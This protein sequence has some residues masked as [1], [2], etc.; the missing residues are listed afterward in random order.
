[1]PP[2]YR[3]PANPNSLPLDQAH[4]LLTNFSSFLTVAIHNLLFYRSIYPPTTFLST[5]AYNLPV[6]QNRHPKVCAWI[7]DAV[8]SVTTQLISGHVSRIAIVMH[9][10]LCGLPE[11]SSFSFSHDYLKPLPPPGAILERW[12]FDVSRFPAWPHKPKESSTKAMAN[13]GKMLGKEAKIE[14]C[15]EKQAADPSVNW[16]DVNEQLRG[17]LKRMAIAAEKMDALPEGCTFTV[18]VELKEEGLA[19]IGH[20]QAWIPSEPNLQTVSKSRFVAGE[21]VGGAKTTPVRSVEAGPLYFECWVEEGKAKEA[22][23]LSPEPIP[24]SQESDI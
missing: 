3:Q 10:P 7:T 2:R 15:R 9:A 18:A 1:M 21:D 13:Y 20:P 12:M 14:E 17:A 19:P 16:A 22:F 8:A 4:P 5:R 6:H 23:S 11:P 24:D